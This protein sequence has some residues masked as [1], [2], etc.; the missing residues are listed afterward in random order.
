MKIKRGRRGIEFVITVETDVGTEHRLVLPGKR[1]ICSRCEGEG[2]H[3][4]PAIGEHAYSSEEFAR[5]FDEEEREEYFTRGGMYDVP[6]E[7]CG[8]EKVITV[9]DEDRMIDAAR[10][11]RGPGRPTVAKSRARILKRILSAEETRRQCD[12]E[13]ESERHILSMMGGG[14]G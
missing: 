1:E 6:C 13:A 5:E 7:R 3:L 11:R 12:E 14:E 4:H 10:I 9:L 2:T 8:G